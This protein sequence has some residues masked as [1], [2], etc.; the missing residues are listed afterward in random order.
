VTDLLVN[1]DAVSHLLNNLVDSDEAKSSYWQRELEDI[2]VDMEGG[3][4]A[5]LPIGNISTKVGAFYDLAHWVL[6]FPWRWIG[7]SYPAF[8]LCQRFGREIANR[9]QRQFTNDMIRQVLTASLLKPY[10]EKSPDDVAFLVIGDGYGVLSSLLKMISPKNKVIMVN[11]AAPLLL[12]LVYFKHAHPTVNIALVT[13]S[14]SMELALKDDQIGGIGIH[15]DQSFLLSESNVG[16]AANVSSMQEM[17]PSAINTYF[18]HLRGNQN[19]STMFYCCNRI[20][21]ILSDNT[22]VRFFEYPWMDADDLIVDEECAW[23]NLTYS[24]SPP[25]WKITPTEIRSHHRLAVLAKERS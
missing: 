5:G 10:V 16:V 13:D 2:A 18:K 7:K 1:D 21:K 20:E 22:A 25:F 19:P 3:T 9:Q 23:D 4:S 11:L 12:D 8:R 17:N 24:A 14:K 15:A 6:Q